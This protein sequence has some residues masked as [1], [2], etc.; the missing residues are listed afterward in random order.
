MVSTF[1]IMRVIPKSVSPSLPSS[2][3][4]RPTSPVMCWG[5]S[6]QRPSHVC[7]IQAAMA[8]AAAS[9][10]PS[11]KSINLMQWE[12]MEVWNHMH[13]TQHVLQASPS[14]WGLYFSSDHHQEPSCSSFPQPS[15]SSL[16]RS[17][18]FYLWNVSVPLA[19]C[20]C[21][22]LWPCH[23]SPFCHYCPAS[24]PAPVSIH[25]PLSCST[26]RS[27]ARSCHAAIP[28][29]SCLLPLT[30]HNSTHGAQY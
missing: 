4:A 13:H 11:R 26:S 17:C 20:H 24:E 1:P 7:S 12:D 30:E 19:P 22:S 6:F 28:E 8:C 10:L 5:C 18:D 3:S 2:L 25:S 29:D 27:P 21:H 23:L 14:S 9:P 15:H 16:T